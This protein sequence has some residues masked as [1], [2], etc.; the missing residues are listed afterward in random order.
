MIPGRV[1]DSLGTVAQPALYRSFA[2]RRVWLGGLRHYDISGI[3]VAAGARYIPARLMKMVSEGA[4]FRLARSS[5]L[6]TF[7]SFP[8]DNLPNGA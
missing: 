3:R 8:H 2:S 7:S 1:L 6:L 4:G 5:A